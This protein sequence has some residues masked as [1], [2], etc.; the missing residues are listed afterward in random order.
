MLKRIERRFCDDKCVSGCIAAEERI[1]PDIKKML[2]LSGCNSLCS[3]DDDGISIKL[4]SNRF[5]DTIEILFTRNHFRVEH[6]R[7][8]NV[9][10]LV[11]KETHLFRS[12]PEMIAFL[13]RTIPVED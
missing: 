8:D 4:F 11:C 1:L 13:A 3:N 9:S 10:G 6:E 2:N 12:P 5:V 7:A